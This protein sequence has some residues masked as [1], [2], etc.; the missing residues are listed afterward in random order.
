MITQYAVYDAKTNRTNFYD[1]KEE[2]VH[3]FWTNV[4][5]FARTY[6]HNTAYMV[7]EKNDDGSQKWYND[8]MTVID[9]PKTQE[10]IEQ[11]ILEAQKTT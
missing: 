2:A 1:T 11:L 10:E 3:A 7:V 9:A 4:V 8:R 5:S 6:Y